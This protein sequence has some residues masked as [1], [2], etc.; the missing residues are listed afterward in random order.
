MLFVDFGELLGHAPGL[1][2]CFK[3]WKRE[4]MSVKKNAPLTESQKFKKE[5]A[6]IAET[7]PFYGW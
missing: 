1:L 6:L 2:T 3:Q 5:T 7:K 4:L